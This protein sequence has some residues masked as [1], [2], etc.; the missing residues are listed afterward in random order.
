MRCSDDNG[1]ISGDCTSQF[2][3]KCCGPNSTSGFEGNRGP[4]GNDFWDAIG[5][6]SDNSAGTRGQEN[7]VGAVVE[8]ETGCVVENNRARADG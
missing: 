5:S 1:G 7:R 3:W 6:D 4:G 2:Q 8:R